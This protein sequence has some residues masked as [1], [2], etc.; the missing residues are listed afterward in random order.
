M[1]WP[2]S[3]ALA[4][5]AVLFAAIATPPPAAAVA[6]VPVIFGNSWDGPAHDLQVIVDNYIGV[7]GAINTRTDYEGARP[8][9]IDPWF[10]V[11]PGFPA[12]MVTEVAGNA[13]INVLGWYKENGL[14]PVIDGVDDGVV[15][16]GPQGGGSG[17]VVSFPSGTTKF[18][19]YL[20]TQQYF[21]GPDGQAHRQIFFTNRFDNDKG[22]HGAGATHV[23]YDGDVQALVYDVSRWKGPNTW[24]VCFEDLDAGGPVTPCCSGTDDDYNDMVFEVQ[25]L[26][27]TPT[28]TLSFGALKS[29]Y[30]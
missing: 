17:T 3:L 2:V 29:R 21:T 25:A 11:G 10:W 24:L 5:V 26:G 4:L 19:F 23:P 1:R 6:P 18:G 12:L 22:L 28:R 15:F 13:D 30:R 16:T 8:G 9:D 7:P 27:A 14:P 20:D